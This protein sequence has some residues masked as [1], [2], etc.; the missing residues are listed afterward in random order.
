M[1]FRYLSVTVL[2]LAS[3]LPQ[4]AR[5]VEAEKP[6]R[7]PVM[8]KTSVVSL[9]SVFQLLND[10]GVPPSADLTVEAMDAAFPFVGGIDDSRPI[11]LYFLA[12]FDLPESKRFYVSIPSKAPGGY[13]AKMKESG[14]KSVVEGQDVFQMGPLFIK[15]AKDRVLLGG[16]ANA[17]AQH[18]DS[19]LAEQFADG[20]LLLTSSSDFRDLRKNFPDAIKALYNDAEN[21]SD[22]RETETRRN[23]KAGK[24][25]RDLSRYY[26]KNEFER[27]D[28]KILKPSQEKLV[29]TLTWGP[30]PA[31]D[32]LETP[33]PV[34]ALPSEC[35]GRF[36]LKLTIPDRDFFVAKFK[37]VW[38]LA[39][40][41][42]T[43][44]SIDDASN[45]FGEFANAHLG[46]NATSV[47]WAVQD[48]AC[49]AYVV[50]Q[51]SA[52]QQDV[53]ARIKNLVES[54]A[55]LDAIDNHKPTMQFDSYPTA[56]GAK[57]FRE[58][59][60]NKEGALVVCVDF[61]PRGKR[62]Y[63]TIS[64]SDKKFIETMPLDQDVP[65]QTL[66]KGAYLQIDAGKM[67]DAIQKKDKKF[68]SP[69]SV[70]DALAKITEPIVLKL[71]P[72]A[73]GLNGELTIP[74]A[75]I[76]AITNLIPKDAP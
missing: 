48:G 24:A 74:I 33:V 16:I 71:E 1:F 45:F 22:S 40:K 14:A 8:S 44:V 58:R 41:L 65:G 64:D 55:K 43:K 6:A 17:L 18:E 34:P 49:V 61:L 29:S 53:E 37:V 4:Q 3:V 11:G 21:N 30:A 9:G 26:F 27:F 10:L 13:M 73:E 69:P 42:D 36:D 72:G 46:G 54:G 15:F 59:I 62:V 2:C 47:G 38:D 67:L 25:G 19:S 12:R 56:A 57:V 51:F 20:K 75:V 66:K 52:E 39:E 32:A 70:T 50:R 60:T 31:W 76:K 23:N 5:A 35:A 7:E 28:F 63:M 68:V